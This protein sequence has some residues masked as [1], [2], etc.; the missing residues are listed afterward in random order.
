M[1]RKQ[2]FLKLISALLRNV[3]YYVLTAKSN[4]GARVR[5]STNIDD[6]TDLANSTKV[7]L[8][9]MLNDTLLDMPRQMRI[10][11]VTT[12]TFPMEDIDELMTAF[13]P[14]VGN[15]G[16]YLGH[17]TPAGMLEAVSK[18]WHT[19][20][21]GSGIAEQDDSFTELRYDFGQ[22]KYNPNTHSPVLVGVIS[23]PEYVMPSPSQGY[24]RHSLQ[25][26]DML[27]DYP[28][29]TLWMRRAITELI[30]VS[31]YHSLIYG[32]PNT[33]RN[34]GTCGHCS[35]KIYAPLTRDI[36]AAKQMLCSEM[37]AMN[38]AL[39][40]DSF[41]SPLSYYVN[42]NTADAVAD[43]YWYGC[44]RIPFVNSPLAEG[45]ASLQIPIASFA[46]VPSIWHDTELFNK[47][48][49]NKNAPAVR[50]HFTE[51]HANDAISELVAHAWDDEE[52][53]PERYGTEN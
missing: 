7:P 29:D 44:P 50:R 38:L 2:V 37:Y 32:D 14:G 47:I 16:A 21:H 48:Y 35:E 20:L 43:S 49:R 33:Y 18:H 13:L 42:T 53:Q 3:D 11:A 41:T 40:D 10:D 4:A 19:A 23:D 24:R 17:D 22:D 5:Y 46:D 30:P 27:K 34:S 51:L 26:Q 36:S 12:P 52:E 31:M 28:D 6:L 39:A 15:P 25:S 9:D 45:L 1:T 8:E